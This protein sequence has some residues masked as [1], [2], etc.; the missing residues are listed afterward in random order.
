MGGE[1][2]GG[3]LPYFGGISNADCV[4]AQ[5]HIVGAI[6]HRFAF[7][8]GLLRRRHHVLIPPA[9]G[10]YGT[11][12]QNLFRDAGFKNWDFS[13]AKMFTFKERL[14]AE[15]RVEFFNLLNHP[16]FVNPSGG[17]GGLVGG[18]D[19]SSQPFGSPCGGLTPDTYSSNP[20]TRFWRARAMQLGLKLSW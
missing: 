6:G 5:G 20:Q 1:T 19:P 18:S 3:G 7:Q 2:G 8:P 4:L 16:T 14:K 15:G 9:Y 10:C 13:V 11:T 17:P 12:A